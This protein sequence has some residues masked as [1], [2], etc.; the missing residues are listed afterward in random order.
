[1]TNNEKGLQQLCDAIR[2]YC[3]TLCPENGTGHKSL[4]E[5]LT[6]L[7][8][9]RDCAYDGDTLAAAQV[10]FL[11]A[12]QATEGLVVQTAFFALRQYAVAA[13]ATATFAERMRVAVAEVGEELEALATAL[14]GGQRNI[15]PLYA[16]GKAKERAFDR[17]LVTDPGGHHQLLF[18]GIQVS[19]ALR[20]LLDALLIL[21]GPRR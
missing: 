8:A 16:R 14:A 6:M 11:R 2:E 15:R 9:T 10:D 12:V 20:Q 18:T 13:G 19:N 7:D 5:I 1:M 21:A 17:L 4:E 3:L